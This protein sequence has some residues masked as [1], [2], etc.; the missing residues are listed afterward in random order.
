MTRTFL[1]TTAAALTLSACMGATSGDRP[2]RMMPGPFAN[3]AILDAAGVQKGSATV[4]A[5]GDGL[6]VEANVMGMAPGTYG[7]HLHQVG[8]CTGPAFTSAGPHWN[9]GMKQHG[10]DNP[11]GSHNGDLPNIVVGAD[12]TGRLEAHV[13]GAFKGDGGLLDADGAA[14]VVHAAADDYKTDP[15]GNSGARVACGVLIAG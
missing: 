7:I 12:G 9:P 11:M 15:S 5:T 1:F 6:H 10:R 14:I 8:T 4:H 13:P 2:A 3:A